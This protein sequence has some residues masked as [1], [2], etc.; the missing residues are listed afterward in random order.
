MYLHGRKLCA[1]NTLR[2]VPNTVILPQSYLKGE[3]HTQSLQISWC[4]CGLNPFHYMDILSCLWLP[5]WLMLHH[6]QGQ[7]GSET[8]ELQRGQWSCPT[9]AYQQESSE[10]GP[11]RKTYPAFHGLQRRTCPIHLE[12]TPHYWTEA[13][14][15][16]SQ[17]SLLFC[18]PVSEQS[19]RPNTW[20]GWKAALCRGHSPLLVGIKFTPQVLLGNDQPLVQG[21]CKADHFSQPA[22]P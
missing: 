14:L 10:S 13:L 12:N 22:R 21:P 1:P 6:G 20:V 2:P 8:T 15:G 5:G 19:Y 3:A 9:S 7:D 17:S 4:D 11:R 18:P 16:S